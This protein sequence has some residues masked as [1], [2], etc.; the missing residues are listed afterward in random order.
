MTLK[1][2]EGE[3]QGT[4][5]NK[6]SEEETGELEQKV[7]R[8]ITY[9]LTPI[10]N[11]S[12]TEAGEKQDKEAKVTRL[13]QEK[14][15]A[16]TRVSARKRHEVIIRELEEKVKRL[17]G[18]VQSLQEENRGLWEY[19]ASLKTKLRKANDTFDVISSRAVYI[20][21]RFHQMYQDKL[22]HGHTEDGKPIEDTE[23]EGKLSSS[24]TTFCSVDEV[25]SYFEATQK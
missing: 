12:G 11:E 3:H 20:L 22:R 2:N 25:Y 18:Q 24:T 4:K 16:M 23:V 9:L 21:R 17:S 5:K 7:V 8:S 1:T 6:K 15:R 13:M 14:K 19:A 10:G